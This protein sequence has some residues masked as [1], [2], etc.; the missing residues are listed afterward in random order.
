MID[1]GKCKEVTVVLKLKTSISPKGLI[2]YFRP[3]KY[4]LFYAL[5]DAIDH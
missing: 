1:L 4:S 5:K 3:K 2:Q